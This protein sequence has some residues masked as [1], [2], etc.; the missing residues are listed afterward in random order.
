MSD[1]FRVMFK[2]P[3]DLMTSKIS[4]PVEIPEEDYIELRI[5]ERDG[6]KDLM[7]Y[8]VAKHYLKKG[9]NLSGED[10]SMTVA[11]GN[12]MYLY[13]IDSAI[14]EGRNPLEEENESHNRDDDDNEYSSSYS[15][16]HSRTLTHKEKAND[17]KI[18]IILISII[19]GIIALF[20]II[21]L[22]LPEDTRT[23]EE[24]ME[25]VKDNAADVWN[26]IKNIGD[27][28]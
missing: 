5:A 12:P 21:G 6:N 22:S 14:A 10:V 11:V 8:Y 23:Q 17:K 24:K 27:K 13:A 26:N 3:S 9:A 2:V 15:N 16:T 7:A 18:K 19:V 1:K 28:E 4:S 20:F 25:E